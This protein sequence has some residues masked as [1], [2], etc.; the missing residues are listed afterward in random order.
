M[1][2]DIYYE[3]PE[4]TFTAFTPQYFE[5]QAD[6]HSF[7]CQSLRDRIQLDFHVRTIRKPAKTW[8]TLDEDEVKKS[9]NFRVNSAHDQRFHLFSECP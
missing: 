9:R 3:C 4:A 1:G 6:K 5:E 8:T 2:D 7:A